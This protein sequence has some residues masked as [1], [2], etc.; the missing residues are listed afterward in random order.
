[1]NSN[2]VEYI[3]LTDFE[4]QRCTD[5]GT[6]RHTNNMRNGVRTQKISKKKTDLEISIEG[7]MG[8]YATM[9]V[10]GLGG[11]DD[12]RTD[13]ADKR[14][15]IRLYNGEFIEVKL[16]GAMGGDFMIEG[17][18]VYELFRAEYGVLVWKP[19][20][21]SPRV[22][23]GQPLYRALA[24]VGW[25]DKSLFLDSMEW[26]DWLP[27]PTYGMPWHMLTPLDRLREHLAWVP[28]GVTNQAS[29]GSF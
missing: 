26:M 25:C 27:R 13:K 18:D 22:A 4:Y 28:V 15:D 23:I 19:P 24:V 1:M 8:E 12:I 6:E 20:A 5:L 2:D 16:T 11:F 10:L 9:S 7:V 21:D 17:A 14:G 29:Q 3:H